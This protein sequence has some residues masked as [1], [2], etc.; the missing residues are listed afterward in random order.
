MSAETKGMFGLDKS[1]YPARM[2]QSWNADEIIQL[3]TS[4]KKKKSIEEIAIEHGRTVGGI[5][6]RRRELA[7]DYHFNDNRPIDEI[8]KFTG[9]T[10]EEVEYAI[11]RRSDT[12]VI[13][14]KTN[15][16]VE[17]SNESSTNMTEV[18]GLL[19]DIQAKINIVLKKIK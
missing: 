2:G 11:K 12:K 16:L 5:N 4:I 14:E 18:L 19:K 10:K 17:P 3:L 7:A 9:L 1:K 15:I 13:K 8:Q 6:S